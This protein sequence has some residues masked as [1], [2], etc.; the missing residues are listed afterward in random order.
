MDGFLTQAERKEAIHFRNIV[1]QVEIAEKRLPH[2]KHKVEWLGCR[3]M[4]EQSVSARAYTRSTS[5]SQNPFDIDKA[6]PN[7]TSSPSSARSRSSV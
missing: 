1:E 7:E 6:A 5:G 2:A 4:L 3:G